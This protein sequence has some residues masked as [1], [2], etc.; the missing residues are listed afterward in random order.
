MLR[1]NFKKKSK[2]KAW[3]P[4][5]FLKE[6]WTRNRYLCGLMSPLIIYVE[7]RLL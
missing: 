6:G 3:W 7:C 5:Q 2:I 4:G 1:P